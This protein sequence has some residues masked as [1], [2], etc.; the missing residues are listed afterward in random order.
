MTCAQCGV[1][2]VRRPGEAR[3]VFSRRMFCSVV[4][5]CRH[6]AAKMRDHSTPLE[7]V[8]RMGWTVTASDCWEWNGWRNDN[9]Y[10]EYGTRI[11]DVKTGEIL[12][13]RLAYI[14]WHGP[15]PEDQEVRHR[16]DNPPCVNPD[17]LEIG[18]H[19]DNMNDAK[20]RGRTARG[21]THGLAKLTDDDVRAI[22]AAS[23]AGESY[24]SLAQRYGVNKFHIGR[25]VRR[26]KWSHVA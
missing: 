19:A 3:T 1:Q 22:R 18:T 5:R 16:C 12:A 11:G 9:G 26:E 2:L 24:R 15:I 7:A 20:I 14:A 6:S 8:Q 13:H 23:A 17:H 21:V 10:G 25:I 4:C